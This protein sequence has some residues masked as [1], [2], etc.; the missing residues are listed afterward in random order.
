[1]Q[2][3][4]NSNPNCAKESLEV[5]GLRAQQRCSISQRLHRAALDAAKQNF[6]PEFMNRLEKV[7]VFENLPPKEMDRILDIE[8]SAVQKRVLALGSQPFVLQYT[9]RA[10]R[11]LLR[12][13]TDAAYGARHLKRAI[14]R[15][16][17][18]PLSNLIA[19][20]QTA[21]AAVIKVDFRSGCKQL[22]FSK[23]D[24]APWCEI[25]PPSSVALTPVFISTIIVFSSCPKRVV[26][27]TD[28]MINAVLMS[29][30]KRNIIR[31]FHA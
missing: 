20:K 31:L 7:V 17:V 24:Q 26:A 4:S 5:T 18:F 30:Q 9:R 25:S 23:M 16:L 1:M 6:S 29:I 15:H 3:C 12:E 22:V 28:R 13:G 11:F 19:S 2:K 8:L 21:N 10:R 27:P 14:E